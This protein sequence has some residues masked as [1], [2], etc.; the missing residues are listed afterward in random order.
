MKNIK[1]CLLALSVVTLIQVSC[2]KNDDSLNHPAE[3]Q[4]QLLNASGEP[5]ISFREGEDILFDYKVVN[6]SSDELVWLYQTNYPKLFEVSQT[7]L[8]PGAKVI[9]TPYQDMRFFAIGFRPMGVSIEPQA[10][11]TLRMT[12][13][14][15]WDRTIFFDLSLDGMYELH[16]EETLK[17]SFFEYLYQPSLPNGTYRV[18]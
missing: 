5:T 9:G 2:S 17:D 1:I 6:K 12:W 14:G 16:G 15:D 3:V 10:E 7:A 8:P 13:Q 4:F 11:A 18:P